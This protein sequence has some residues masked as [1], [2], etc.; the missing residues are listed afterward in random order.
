MIVPI[1]LFSFVAADCM[2]VYVLYD[3]FVTL[4]YQKWQRLHRT[5]V[6]ISYGIKI[7][8]KKKE[9]YN[10]VDTYCPVSSELQHRRQVPSSSLSSRLLFAPPF[11]RLFRARLHL[12]LQVP[13]QAE[14]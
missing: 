10:L 7:R 3:W 13:P 9:K 5:M 12:L 6:Y 2:L 4:T 8:N 1:I 11:P 14:N